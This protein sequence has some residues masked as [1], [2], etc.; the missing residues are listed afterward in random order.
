MLSI[1]V[2][3]LAIGGIGGLGRIGGIGGFGRTG[4]FGKL[5]FLLLFSRLGLHGIYVIGAIY[6]I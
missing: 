6:V 2:I 5:G 4:I 3:K 1:T